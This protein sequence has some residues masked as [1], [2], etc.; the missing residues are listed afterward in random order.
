MKSEYRFSEYGKVTNKCTSNGY[1]RIRY[2][3]THKLYHRAFYEMY[4]GCCILSGVDIDHINGIKTD[5][6][7]GNLRLLR[8]EDHTKLHHKKDFSNRSCRICNMKT[9]TNNLGY[10][11]WYGDQNKGWLCKI[12]YLRK[13]HA[14]QKLS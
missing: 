1:L 3:N 2:K 6:S 5:N 14:K 11:Q 8:K 10:E 4:Y 7:I 13:Y 9:H 12:C